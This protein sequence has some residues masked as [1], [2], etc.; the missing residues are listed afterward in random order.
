MKSNFPIFTVASLNGQTE[1]K[2]H[3]QPRLQMP[4][5]SIILSIGMIFSGNPKFWKLT[6]DR[7]CRR[8]TKIVTQNIASSLSLDANYCLPM[9]ICTPKNLTH[10]LFITLKSKDIKVRQPGGQ[11]GLLNCPWPVGYAVFTI[12]SQ[13]CIGRFRRLTWVAAD[14]Q[15]NGKTICCLTRYRPNRPAADME[16]WR[17]G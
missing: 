1:G 16:N 4:M 12:L 6:C 11:R 10:F 9:I 15:G 7:R 13:L 17:F 2:E 14:I 8:I 3:E 5:F